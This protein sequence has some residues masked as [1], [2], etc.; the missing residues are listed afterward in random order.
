MNAAVSLVAVPTISSAR[1][2]NEAP[3]ERAWAWVSPSAGGALKRTMAGSMRATSLTWDASLPS[4]SRG[5]RF[6]PS[7]PRR[8]VTDLDGNV[9]RRGGTFDRLLVMLALVT[10]TEMP[11]APGSAYTPGLSQMSGLNQGLPLLRAD[12][13]R[14]R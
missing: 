14:S 1:S 9:M 11:L 10:L 3:I 7:R 5:P 13:P 4:T 12:R 6:P 2:S 8:G